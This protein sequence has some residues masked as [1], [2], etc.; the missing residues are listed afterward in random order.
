MPKT[1]TRRDLRG[2]PA[3]EGMRAFQAADGSRNTG[4]V[5]P[6][7]TAAVTKSPMVP[8]IRKMC[9]GLP[10]SLSTSTVNRGRSRPVDGGIGPS[11]WRNLLARS[12]AR[13]LTRSL[14]RDRSIPF[15][16]VPGSGFQL[17]GPVVGWG[18]KTKASV[19]SGTRKTRR[20]IEL[21]RERHHTRVMKLGQKGLHGLSTQCEDVRLGVERRVVR[22]C[23]AGNGLPI[24]K[25]PPE[26]D[27]GTDF[28]A[29]GE[30]LAASPGERSELQA[31][32][33]KGWSRPKTLP[34]PMASAAKSSARR[35]E[36]NAMTWVI[37]LMSASALT[38]AT[39]RHWFAVPGD[40]S[41]SRIVSGCPSRASCNRVT[42]PGLTERT[43][44]S[45]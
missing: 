8:P 25:R 11:Y 24:L 10:G 43:P 7:P 44:R 41:G 35:S 20:R 23:L 5:L 45:R 4:P 9:T 38:G 39:I 33:I 40:R 14:N 18:L 27:V 31:A 37:A 28:A 34:S 42:V 16:S 6:L 36:S 13:C 3:A 21:G 32:T 12:S 26:L 30:D 15:A 22:A 29:A 19:R 17:A 2:S 1:R